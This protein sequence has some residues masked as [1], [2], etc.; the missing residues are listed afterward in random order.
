MKIF[1]KQAEKTSRREDEKIRQGRDRK[2]LYL[3]TQLQGGVSKFVG[4]KVFRSILTTY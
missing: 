3:T 4:G 2:K 1:K